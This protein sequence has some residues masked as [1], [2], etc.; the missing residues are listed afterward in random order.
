LSTA[1]FTDRGADRFGFVHRTMAECLSARRYAGMELRRLRPLFFQ[2][3]ATD[4][5]VIPQL[6]QTASWLCED[7]PQFFE[8]VLE[9]DVEVL[10][11]TEVSRISDNHRE[12]IVILLLERAKS[13]KLGFDPPLYLAGLKHAGLSQQLSRVL[14]DPASENAERALAISIAKECKLQDLST[15]LFALLEGA[16]TRAFMLARIAD[17]LIAIHKGNPG[18]LLALL[19]PE[20]LARDTDFRVRGK[21]LDALVPGTLSVEESLKYLETPSG[22]A[23]NAY[24]F[25]LTR[26]PTLISRELIPA[27]L[28]FLASKDPWATLGSPFRSL[29]EHVFAMALSH[30]DDSEVAD[31]TAAEWIR[32]L[33][34]TYGWSL[35]GTS[36]IADVLAGSPDIRRK[37]A[38]AVIKLLSQRGSLDPTS[39]LLLWGGV[40]PILQ[41]DDLLWLLDF[42]THCSGNQFTVAG[43]VFVTGF[44]WVDLSFFGKHSETILKA[45][46]CRISICFYM[47]TFV[48]GL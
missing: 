6:A 10:L 26:L 47:T 11:R 20:T 1:I 14:L 13:G 46:R 39:T 27:F 45:T 3:P 40:F 24:S 23:V 31:L 4:R 34:S 12:R 8:A 44:R 19:K 16:E 32:I 48:H 33:G 36:Q 41:E 5:H 9:C 7:H 22:N 37:L 35:S 18:I 17:A 25:F 28:R 29:G 43:S 38:A 15:V 30:L 2:G 21:A 42:L